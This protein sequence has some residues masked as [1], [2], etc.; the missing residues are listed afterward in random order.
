[1]S[2]NQKLDIFRVLR[3]LDQRDKGFYKSL[4]EE[5]R[6]AL[7]F[8][9]L[10]RWA[11]GTQDNK[12][13]QEWYVTETNL[14]VNKNFWLL[15]KHPE[16]LWM[17]FSQI[18]STKVIRHEYI[19]RHQDKKDPIL[20]SLGKIYPSAKLSDLEM[21]KTILPAER[22]KVLVKEYDEFDDDFN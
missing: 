7:S 1:M 9:L 8:Y 15:N 22:I 12:I 10:L 4:N 14:A 11:S 17:L 21:L 2:K 20:N 16:L 5:E 18:G 13:L 3:A 6:K 19:K